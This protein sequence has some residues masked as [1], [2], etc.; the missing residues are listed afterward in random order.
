MPIAL[1]QGLPARRILRAEGIDVPGRDELHRRVQRPLRIGLVNLMPDKIATETQ[2]AR[3]LGAAAVPVELVLSVPDSYRAKSAPSG[4]MAAF[5][6]PWSDLGDEPLDGLV[7]TGAPVETLPFEAVTYWSDLC[8]VFDRAKARGIAGLYI[9]WAAQAALRHFHGVP[10]HELDAKLFGVFRQRVARPDAA[11]LRGFGATFPTPVSRHTEVR[12]A[13]LPAGL[14]V[15]ADSPVSGLCLVEDRAVSALC[16]FN[17]LEYDAGTLAAEFHRDRQAGKPIALPRHY[18]PDDDPERA[19]KNVWR[20][21]AHLLFAN[22]LGDIQRTA[23]AG[24]AA[25]SPHP[26]AWRGALR[27]PVATNFSCRVR[28]G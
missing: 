9:C 2:V 13:D 28:A 16:M 18:F 21:H 26:V 6:R 15:L 20:R 8:A 17:H 10:K 4:H 3:L 12:A 23:A 1:P 7:V 24:A 14:A 27:A 22:W 11:L 5:Y 19:P 25:P